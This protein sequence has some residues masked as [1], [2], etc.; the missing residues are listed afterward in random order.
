MKLW[1]LRPVEDASAW[2]PWFDK[3][4]G[5]VI[6]ADTELCARKIA[7]EIAGEE[8][9]RAWLDGPNNPTVIN[10]P[11][12]DRKQSTCVELTSDGEVGLVIQDFQRA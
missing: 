1:L 10:R 2:E 7:D 4:F 8:N 12:L 5:S 6:R 3:C 11:W 9:K